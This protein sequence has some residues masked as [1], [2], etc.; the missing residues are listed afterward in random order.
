MPPADGVVVAVPVPPPQAGEAVIFVWGIPFQPEDAAA[1]KIA[2]RVLSI[3]SAMACVALASAILQL[4]SHVS[5]S[6]GIMS[7]LL[8]PC[9]GF[10]GASRKSR[11]MVLCFVV[12]N[13]V[14]SA[15]FIGSFITTEAVFRGDFISCACSPQCRADKMSDFDAGSL[16]EICSHES[17]SRIAYWV[18]MG[19]AFLMCALQLLGCT[20]GRRLLHTPYFERAYAA[21]SLPLGQPVVG[22]YEEAPQGRAFAPGSGHGGYHHPAYAEPGAGGHTTGYT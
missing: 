1:A 17:A 5:V 4:I 3:S 8:I 2:R 15:F 10:F 19:L 11:V 7:A 22:Y 6:I 16:D 13:I 9:C 20:Y 14:V 18:G 21:D 12:A